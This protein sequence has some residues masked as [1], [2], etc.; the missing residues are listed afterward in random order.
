MLYV[1]MCLG[2]RRDHPRGHTVHR[3]KTVGGCLARALDTVHQMKRCPSS[4]LPW[5]EGTNSRTRSLLPAMSRRLIRFRSKPETA[6]SQVRTQACAPP[7]GKSEGSCKPPDPVGA[8]D[9]R[10]QVRTRRSTSLALHYPS[11]GV[12]NHSG[13]RRILRQHNCWHLQIVRYRHI[14]TGEPNYERFPTFECNK[15]AMMRLLLPTSTSV[16]SA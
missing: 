8:P 6:R 14:H 10:S 2:T 3:K 9:S 4:E 16:I 13:T 7:I 15:K 12:Y 5:L 1:W 11:M